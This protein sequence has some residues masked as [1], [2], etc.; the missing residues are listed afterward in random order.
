MPVT[1]ASGLAPAVSR[2]T[3]PAARPFPAASLQI[4]LSYW[5][6]GHRQAFSFGYQNIF[7]RQAGQVF[8]LVAVC[9]SKEDDPFLDPSSSSENDADDSSRDEAGEH[10]GA[11]IVPPAT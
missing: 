1:A 2:R 4:L 5:Q 11:F 7:L 3:N 9:V 8:F 6:L 10:V